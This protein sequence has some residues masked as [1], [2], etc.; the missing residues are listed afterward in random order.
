MKKITF[1]FENI[2]KVE[3]FLGATLYCYFQSGSNEATFKFPAVEGEYKQKEF[4]MNLGDTLIKN[5][6]GE[7]FIKVN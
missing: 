5:R 2:K 4:K 6:A 7:I 3:E 1:R